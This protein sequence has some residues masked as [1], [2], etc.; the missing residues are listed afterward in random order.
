[1][2]NTPTLQ[3]SPLRAGLGRGVLLV[4][5]L[6]L[7]IV[8]YR[9]R[10]R[11]PF[12]QFD[13][14][15]A[16]AQLPLLALGVGLVT[17]AVWLGQ[18][19]ALIPWHRSAERPTRRRPGWYHAAT[20]FGLVGMAAFVEAQIQFLNLPQIATLRPDDQLAVLVGS[21][22]LLVLGVG[23]VP[24][25][26]GRWLGRLTWADGAEIGAVFLLTGVAV[27]VR[28]WQLGTGIHAFV[29]ELNFATVSTMFWDTERHTPLTLPGVRSFPFM[30]PYLQNHFVTL[31]G[32]DLTGLR[33]LSVVIGAAAV[34]GVYL[35]G[36]ALFDRPTAF[37]GALL[38][39]TFPPHV[40]FSRLA[41][42]N[43][44][45]PTFGVFALAFLARGFKHNRRLDFALAGV[46]LGLTQYWYEVGRV[47]FPVLV[48]AWCGWG[49]L[50]GY[51]R[52]RWRGLL[53]MGVLAV[54]VGGPIYITLMHNDLPLNARVQE[55]GHTG[56]AVDLLENVDPTDAEYRDGLLLAF[57][58]YVHQPEFGV[59]YMGGA[60]GFV[61]WVLV[62]LLLVGV[63]AVL[64]RPGHPAVL[65]VGVL[66]LNALFTSLISTP[67]LAT[68][69]VGAFPVLALLL[70]LGVRVL[71][72]MLLG[73]RL[74]HA[75]RGAVLAGMVLV[76]GAGALAQGV[77]YFETHLPLYNRQFRDVDR[78]D[79]QD[80]AF[81]LAAL[82]GPVRGHIVAEDVANQAFLQGIIDFSRTHPAGA[83]ITVNDPHTFRPWVL[84]ANQ[85]HVF[86]IGPGDLHTRTLLAWYFPLGQPQFSP[87][88]VPERFELAMFPAR[89][90]Y[91]TAHAPPVL[92][93]GAQRYLDAPLQDRLMA[94]YLERSHLQPLR[95]CIDFP[96][97]VEVSP[98]GR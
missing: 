43:I 65:L 41:L 61:L 60:G 49:L 13:A 17:L 19:G 12:Y 42:N 54:I 25:P 47:L 77:Y 84:N 74:D 6:V 5:L 1:M 24:W 29:D 87:Y 39:A 37:A 58:T 33:A 67:Q 56:S 51:A 4:A 69:Y 36:R 2:N 81:R 48:V 55:V 50:V 16:A 88:N 93:L 64:A 53:I 79:A 35:L 40:H 85:Q 90:R 57:M 72:R 70:G 45:E 8:G 11:P 44:A 52:T 32:R 31:L 10:P 20:A 66:V 21:I 62:P 71:G 73:L 98:V 23:A 38:L 91:Y 80:A 18:R 95:A 28:A 26:V 96:Q 68:R 97:A 59:Y 9:L 83:R 94:C 82:P 15:Y 46:M 27:A 78:Y 63:G 92:L 86:F 7:L 30:F 76:A 3:P 14:D 75:W 89:G 22:V 34:P